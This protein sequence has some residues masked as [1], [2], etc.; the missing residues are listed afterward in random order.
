MTR[1]AW[2]PGLAAGLAG[3]AVLALRWLGLEDWPLL[4]ALALDVAVFAAVYLGGWLIL[5]GGKATL[6]EL[7]RLVRELQL[8]RSGYL[9]EKLNRTPP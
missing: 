3:A 7:V 9:L 2:R 5:P 4:G 6:L 8:K 1:S